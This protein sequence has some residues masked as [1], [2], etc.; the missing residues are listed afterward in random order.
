MQTIEAILRAVPRSWKDRVDVDARHRWKMRLL[1]LERSLSKSTAPS[2][3]QTPAPPSPAGPAAAD[4]SAVV[5]GMER[6]LE[7]KLQAIEEL[8][9]SQVSG[10][11]PSVLEDVSALVKAVEGLMMQVDDLVGR[12]EGRDRPPAG[13]DRVT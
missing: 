12:V 10:P 5:N 11:A 9:T 6:R 1:R 7:R 13:T 2:P 4:F 8:L 3:S